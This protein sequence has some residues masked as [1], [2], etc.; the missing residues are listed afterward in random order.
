MIK[1]IE[2]IVCFFSKKQKHATDAGL[3]VVDSMVKAKSLYK[4]LIIKAHP[5][6]NQAKEELAKSITEEINNNRYNYH[7]L[8]IIKKRIQ[9]ELS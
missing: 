4:E 6:K 3:N 5:D 1:W 9:N 7:E 2:R 8:L